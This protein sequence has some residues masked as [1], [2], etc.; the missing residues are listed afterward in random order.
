MSWF[1]LKINYSINHSI[2]QCAFET[3]KSSRPLIS[4]DWLIVE[5]IASSLKVPITSVFICS[6]TLWKGRHYFRY[7]YWEVKDYQEDSVFSNTHTH[8]HTNTH[9]NETKIKTAAATQFVYVVVTQASFVTLTMYSLCSNS[10]KE[11]S[12]ISSVFRRVYHAIL[13]LVKTRRLCRT[14]V[15]LCWKGGLTPDVMQN[16]LFMRLNDYES[17]IHHPRSQLL[18]IEGHF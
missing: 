1:A 5:L 2:N 6:S 12:H 18:I 8:T 14:P 16:L 13:S 11:L 10:P 9:K 4:I 7:V 17:G 3:L 15:L